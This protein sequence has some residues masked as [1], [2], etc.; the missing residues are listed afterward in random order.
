MS[1]SQDLDN[2]FDLCGWFSARRQ[3][4]RNGKAISGSP[5]TNIF[6]KNSLLAMIFFCSFTW[7]LALSLFFLSL[8]ARIATHTNIHHII[9]GK[10]WGTSWLDRDLNM[11]VP[12]KLH[13]TPVPSPPGCSAG[14]L[15]D[16]S[17]AVLAAEGQV[18]FQL[19]RVMP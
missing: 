14:E 2:S 6:C 11:C 9:S 5:P 18:G 1:H 17:R 19:S 15:S 13:P 12:V 3:K 16:L 8:N 7:L 10:D 4:Y